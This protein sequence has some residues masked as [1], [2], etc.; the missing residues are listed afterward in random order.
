M[1]K[2]L[3]ES[4]GTVGVNTQLRQLKK[5]AQD[6]GDHP[7]L[8]KRSTFTRPI[9]FIGQGWVNSYRTEISLYCSTFKVG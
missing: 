2:R 6:R 5:I 1:K 4:L 8:M 9:F 3:D 7:N